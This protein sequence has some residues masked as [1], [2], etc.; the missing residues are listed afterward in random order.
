MDDAGQIQPAAA[1]CMLIF[2][3]NLAARGVHLV[4]ARLLGRSQAWRSR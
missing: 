4:L 2:Y 1:M 3:T